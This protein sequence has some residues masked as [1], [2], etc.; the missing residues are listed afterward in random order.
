MTGKINLS[1]TSAP[2][3]SNSIVYKVNHERRNPTN[4]INSIKSSLAS[5]VGNSSYPSVDGRKNSL[6]DTA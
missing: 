6:F 1:A 3:T 5:F 2:L 4:A